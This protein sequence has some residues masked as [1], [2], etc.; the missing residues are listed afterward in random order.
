MLVLL[1]LKGDCLDLLLFEEPF[2]ADRRSNPRGGCHPFQ[3]NQRMIEKKPDRYDTIQVSARKYR[4]GRF[5]EVLSQEHVSRTLK[6][7]VLQGRLSHAYLFT[8]PRG[9]GKTTMA[10][11]LAKAVNCENPDGAEPCDKCSMCEEIRQGH[12]L[13]II[14]I[15]GASNRRIADIR[16]LRQKVGF[17]PSRANCKVYIIDEVHMLTNEAFNALLK[18]LEEPPENVIFIFATTEPHKVP[19]TI[20]SRC[21]RFDFRSI[22]RGEIAQHLNQVAKKEGLELSGETMYVLARKADGSLRDALSLFDQIRAFADGAFG[23]KDVI[24]VT[25]MIEDEIFLDMLGKIAAGDGVGIITELNSI[26]GEGSDLGELYDCFLE[27]L[28]NLIVLKVDES[29]GGT[30]DVADSVLE[31]Y[32]KLIPMFGTDELLDMFD[33][34]SSNR[35]LFRNSELKKILLETI[36]LKFVTSRNRMDTG[37]NPAT[38][39]HE[40]PVIDRPENSQPESKEDEV[41]KKFLAILS[42]RKVTLY[43]LLSS[44]RPVALEDNTFTSEIVCGNSFLMDQLRMPEHVSILNECISE[45]CGKPVCVKVRQGSSEAGSPSRNSPRI[46]DRLKKILDAE[47][48][49]S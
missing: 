5:S 15:D 34:L 22:A 39:E 30:C 7:A 28:R 36:L 38:V 37:S 29:L 19:L 24:A 35:V 13:D 14:E 27:H 20:T 21:Q 23:E 31:G 9:V 44:A 40:D 11:V 41:W 49:T 32:L 1:N 25:G 16:D 6:N 17:A 3:G 12:A 47:E 48:I 42:K 46:A 2:H 33:H 26:T 4:P 10:R 8:G 18:I 43:G 45:A